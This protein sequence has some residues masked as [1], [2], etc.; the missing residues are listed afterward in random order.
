M[1]TVR[2]LLDLSRDGHFATVL[3][4][5]L[6]LARRELTLANAGHLPPVLVANHHAELLATPVG[7]PIG[8][9]GP[10]G[11]ESVTVSIPPTATLLLYTDGLIERRGENLDVG[12]SRLVKMVASVD[13]PLE[14]V[15]STIV[16]ALVPDGCDDDTA[17]LGVRWRDSD[18][19]PD[20]SVTGSGGDIDSS[21]AGVA[22]EETRSGTRE[23]VLTLRGELDLSSIDAVRADVDDAIARG[24]MVLVF[25]L[26]GLDFMDSSGLALL[27]GVIPR[28]ARLEIRNPSAAV[29]RIID[30]TGLAATLPMTP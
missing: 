18:N 11:Y 26:R 29:R 17:I 13:E 24:P 21:E 30:I 10:G 19:R 27:L 12:L 16:T 28:V 7:P 2:G 4:G 9:P 5:V 3:C 15:L 22:V 23:I 25:E 14:G 8:V 1:N 6:D 20:D